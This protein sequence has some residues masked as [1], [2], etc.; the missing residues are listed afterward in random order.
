MDVIREIVTAFCVGSVAAGVAAMLLPSGKTEKV[1]RMLLGFFLLAATL[2]PVISGKAL[3]VRWDVAPAQ[4]TISDTLQN[5]VQEQERTAAEEAVRV[6]IEL[7]LQSLNIIGAEVE[8]DTDIDGQGCI[9][10]RQTRLYLPMN[11]ADQAAK[12]EDALQSML[13]MEVEVFVQGE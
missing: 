5:T 2:S 11:A 10:I 6:Q 13:G 7:V 1:M 8:L 3:D 9:S 4:A 12:A